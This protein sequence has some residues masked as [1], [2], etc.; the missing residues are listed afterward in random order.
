MSTLKKLLILML[1]GSTLLFLCCCGSTTSEEEDIIEE[2]EVSGP[3]SLTEYVTANDM[4]V[5]YQGKS[6]WFNSKHTLGKDEPIIGVSV[7]SKDGTVIYYGEGAAENAGLESLGKIAGYSDEDVA[8]ALAGTATED[9][10]ILKGEWQVD[11]ETDQT[12]N[13]VIYETLFL[14]DKDGEDA[15]P[16]LNI[17]ED[18]MRWGQIYDSTFLLISLDT[19]KASDH[20]FAKKTWYVRD[21]F[22]ELEIYADTDLS[23]PSFFVDQFAHGAYLP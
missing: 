14:P 8:N 6:D 1:I 4:L 17:D 2:E 5:A 20:A 13:S 3:M 9:T 7:F 10:F 15:I 22:E 16:V 21:D 23:N 18:D 11:L 12:G 19:D